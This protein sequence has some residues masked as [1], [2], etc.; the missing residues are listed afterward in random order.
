MPCVLVVN[1]DGLPAA[2]KAVSPSTYV[3][4]R[5]VRGAD[6]PSPADR[7]WPSGEQWVRELEAMNGFPPGADA[8]QLCN[9]WFTEN[10]RPA[11]EFVRFRDFYLQLMDAMS[12]RGR[13][14]T[15]L[16]L[17]PG[18]LELNQFE[19]LR[20]V[21][22][23]AERQGHI[24]NYHA[25]GSTQQNWSMVD[26]AAYMT[27]RWVPW[28][29]DYP[30][31]RILFGEAGSYN[32]PRFR[33]AG[34]TLNMMREFHALLKPYAAQV[35]GACWWTIAGTPG[36]WGGDDWASTLSQYERWQRD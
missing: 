36:N 34:T 29:R 31:L 32:S 5:R 30:R 26:Q 6:D 8:Y 3:V 28:V 11:A 17:R 33:D 15:V 13:I 21:F 14:C 19:V 10:S 22:A 27:M 25:Y 23:Q 9:E 18:H 35:I 4:F 12:A 20:P 16:D 7:G 2:I 1:H 24:L